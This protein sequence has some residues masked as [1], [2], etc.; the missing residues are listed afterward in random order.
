MSTLKVAQEPMFLRG[1]EDNPKPSIYRHLI[2][3]AKASG[4]DYWQIWHLLAFVPRPRTTSPRSPTP[5]CT[6]P[7]PSAPACANS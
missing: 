2:E 7:A 5:S 3:N 4:G 1:V 6:S